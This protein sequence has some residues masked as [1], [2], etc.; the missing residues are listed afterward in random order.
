MIILKRKDDTINFYE[1]VNLCKPKI[2][3][4]PGICCHRKANFE[5]VI[6]FL[7]K[8]SRVVCVSYDGFDETEK[9]VFSNMATSEKKERNLPAVFHS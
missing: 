1:S 2:I 9:V 6:T 7:T 5:E 4:L 3:L 8:N